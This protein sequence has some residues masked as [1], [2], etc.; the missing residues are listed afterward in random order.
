MRSRGAISGLC[1][2]SAVLFKPAI[3]PLD[4]VLTS[5][6]LNHVTKQYHGSA[7]KSLGAEYEHREQSMPEA[8]GDA[9]LGLAVRNRLAFR[10]PPYDWI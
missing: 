5:K 4:T 3:L 7:K 2:E 10:A 1:E 6:Y 8:L 9:P